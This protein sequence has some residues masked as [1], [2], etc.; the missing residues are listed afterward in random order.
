MVTHISSI[1]LVIS[2]FKLSSISSSETSKKEFLDWFFFNRLHT[3]INGFPNLLCILFQYVF[4]LG[5]CKNTR[6]IQILGVTCCQFYLLLF[7]I[8]LETCCIILLWPLKEKIKG[9]TGFSGYW[10]FVWPLILCLLILCHNK[11]II[12]AK[13]STKN[14]FYGG[15]LR[16]I[17]QNLTDGISTMVAREKLTIGGPVCLVKSESI[18]F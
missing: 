17:V 16:I 1:V 7:I 2:R 4:Q 18:E 14:N 8:L 15:H 12:P 10:M 5:K 3:I 11:D 6:L 13:C 9:L